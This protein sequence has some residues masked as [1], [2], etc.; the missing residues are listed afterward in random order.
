MLKLAGSALA[1]AAALTLIPLTATH[2]GDRNDSRRT[3]K[4]NSIRMVTRSVSNDRRPDRRQVRRVVNRSVVIVNVNGGKSHHF[5]HHGPRNS[6][7]GDV[8]IDFRD[9][10]GQWSYGGFDAGVATVR[11]VPNAKVIDVDALDFSAACAMEA[12]VCVIRP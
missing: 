1:I 11:T 2:A 8:R 10:V 4:Q 12:G 6:Y 9:G 3:V 5:R 7:S